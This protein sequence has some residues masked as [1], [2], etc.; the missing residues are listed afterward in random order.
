M[1]GLLEGLVASEQRADPLASDS[2]RCRPGIEQGGA[3]AGELVDALLGPGGLLAPGRGDEALLLEGT[4]RPVEVGE[5]DPALVE[6][7]FEILRELV[8]VA[9][10]Q[11]SSNSMWYFTT[12]ASPSWSPVVVPDIRRPDGAWEKNETSKPERRP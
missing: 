7:L 8:A 3:L 5:V 10:L 1:D 9:F 12:Q 4:Q 11:G 6:Q 2:K